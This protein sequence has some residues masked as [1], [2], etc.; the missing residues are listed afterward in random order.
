MKMLVVPTVV[1]CDFAAYGKTVSARRTATLLAACAGISLATVSD[2]QASGRGAVLAVSSV[3]TGVAQKMLN[4][5][6][7]QRGGL[8]TLQLMDRA[9]PWMVL[10]GNANI[11]S[12]PS[13]LF[14][15]PP[16]HL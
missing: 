9:F 8:S 5:H 3:L 4:S 16:R 15:P 11:E 14:L 12:S 10:I 2:V 6:M 13:H 7:Q 1:V